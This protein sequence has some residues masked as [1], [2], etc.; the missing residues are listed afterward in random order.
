MDKPVSMLLAISAVMHV[1]VSI[2]LVFVLRERPS[3]V[4]VPQKSRARLDLLA[5]M[6]LA[7]IATL[8]VETLNAPEFALNLERP[9]R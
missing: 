2:V 6:S 3:N 7:T 4:G 5:Q 8:T 1:V 9:D